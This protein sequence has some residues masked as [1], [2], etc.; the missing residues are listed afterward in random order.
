MCVKSWKRDKE[1]KDTH[2]THKHNTVTH[3]N[4]QHTHACKHT[5]LTSVL[6]IITGRS[7][8]NCP[9]ENQREGADTARL[10]SEN[11]GQPA[12]PNQRRAVWDKMAVQ[13]NENPCKGEVPTGQ[14]RP[15]KLLHRRVFF[16]PVHQPNHCHTSW[17]V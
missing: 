14:H 15:D 4:T 6:Y 1:Y 12:V 3:H 5:T 9:A 11:P 13:G 2:T 7:K 16:P 17:F 8:P 10:C